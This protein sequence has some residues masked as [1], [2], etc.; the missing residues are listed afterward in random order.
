MAK[1]MGPGRHIGWG[2][3]TVRDKVPYELVS[4][5]DDLSLNDPKMGALLW[6]ASRHLDAEITAIKA[7]LAANNKR[8]EQLEKLLDFN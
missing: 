1:Q 8:L 4:G 2:A 7:A 6:S 3:Q 5:N